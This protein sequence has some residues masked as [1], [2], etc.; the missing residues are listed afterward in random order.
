LGTSVNDFVG[1][2]RTAKLEISPKFIIRVSDVA[3]AEKYIE[4]TIIN[5][6]DLSPS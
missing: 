3:F 2:G 1:Y 6:M 5:L 4:T